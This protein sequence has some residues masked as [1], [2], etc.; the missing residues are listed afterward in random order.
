MCSCH[1]AQLRLGHKLTEKALKKA[2]NRVPNRLTTAL[3]EQDCCKHMPV[4]VVL[5]S[6]FHQ[7]Q[8]T[9]MCHSVLE[10]KVSG[11]GWQIA[12]RQQ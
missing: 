10:Q 7:A 5:G 12:G 11:P 6:E 4:S 9:Q 3:E 1:T 8:V 2:S